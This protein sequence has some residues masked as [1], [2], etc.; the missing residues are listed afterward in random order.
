MGQI[1]SESVR[2]SRKLEYI[3]VKDKESSEYN[4]VESELN[5]IASTTTGLFRCFKITMEDRK[6]Y[7]RVTSGNPPFSHTMTSNSFVTPD[8]IFQNIVHLINTI[9]RSFV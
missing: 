8:C 5:R 4:V 3:F 1:K 9:T 2:K 7:I 6:S